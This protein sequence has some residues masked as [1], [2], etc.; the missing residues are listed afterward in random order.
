[1]PMPHLTAKEIAVL[2]QT[3]DAFF[4]EIYAGRFV[5]NLYLDTHDY[6]SFRDAVEG[7]RRR[8][9]VRIR[10]YGALWG[11][12]AAPVLELKHKRGGLGYKE[13]YP[14]VPFEIGP[15]VSLSQLGTV[16]EKS[17]LSDALRVT[18]RGLLPTLV[19]RYYRTYHLSWDRQ[20]RATIDSSLEYY[21][22]FGKTISPT[23]IKSATNVLE[24]KYG[25]DYDMGARDIL[26]Q[27]RY[28]VSKNSKYVEGV[29][30]TS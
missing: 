13:S 18:L 17:D 12:L 23:P 16:W 11:Q 28:R 4:S 14:L 10:W 29:V 25:V 9:K 5:N 2:L 21:R 19:N 27:L 26:S 15:H 30:R 6:A 7:H 24:L 3:S 1:M 20:Y 22:V 8:R